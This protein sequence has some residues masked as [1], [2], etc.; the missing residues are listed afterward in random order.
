MVLLELPGDT[1]MKDRKSFVFSEASQQGRHSSLPGIERRKFLSCP[2][3][4]VEQHWDG[5]DRSGEGVYPREESCPE[6]GQ[7]P[8]LD[9]FSATF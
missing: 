4:E 7:G 5:S 9:L 3:S 2:K 6:R 8:A 1:R